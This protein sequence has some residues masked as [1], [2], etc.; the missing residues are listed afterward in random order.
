MARQTIHAKVYSRTFG[1]AGPGPITT[2]TK[3]LT[4]ERRDG[5]GEFRAEFPANDTRLDLITIKENYLEFE[6]GGKF[7]FFGLVEQMR[8]EMDD[9]GKQIVVISGRDQ[10]GALAEN[11]VGELSMA[12][13]YDAPAQILGASNVPNQNFNLSASGQPI[14][15]TAYT[16]LFAGESALSALWKV[17]SDLGEHFRTPKARLLEVVWMGVATPDA[18]VRLV[19]TG[20]PLLHENPDVAIIE[21]VERDQNGEQMANRIYPFGAGIGAARLTLEHATNAMPTGYTMN[22]S[23]NYIQN[24]AQQ[25][26]P[27]VRKAIQKTWNHI[28]VDVGQTYVIEV[29]ATATTGAT[30]IA[31]ESIAIP[32]AS[33]TLL[34]LNGGGTDFVELSANVSVG[35]NVLNVVATTFDVLDTDTLIYTN[36]EA[37]EAA[38]RQLAFAALTYLQRVS[39]PSRMVSYRLTVRGLPDA[40]T[41]GMKIPVLSQAPGFRI[42]DDLIILEIR[43]T[44]T[45]QGQT[46]AV[47]T[48]VPIDWFDL[49]EAGSIAATMEDFRVSQAQGQPVAYSSI[50]SAPTAYSAGSAIDINGSNVISVKR[51]SDGAITIG[52]TGGLEVN[53][54]NGIKID[55]NALTLDLATDPGLEYA[56]GKLQ[57]KLK[58]GMTAMVRDAGGIYIADAIAGNGLTIN[59][60]TKVMAVGAGDGIDVDA[61]SVAVDV[62]DIIDGSSAYGLT[63]SGNNIRIAL[64]TNSGL[65]FNAGLAMGTPSALSVG[66][67]SHV[68]SSTHAHAVTTSSDVGTSPVA[69]ILASNASGQLTLA[70][71]TLHGNLVFAGGDRSVTASNKLTLAPSGDLLLDPTGS[72]LIPT[73]QEVKTETFS[74]LVTG[75][76]G[77]RMW[78][79]G[80]NYRQM[81]IG[82]IKADEMFVRVFVADE[83]RIDR[84]EEYWSKSYGVVETDF[85]LPADEA[86]VDVWFE[87][88]PGL[89]AANLFSTSDW[90]LARTIDWDTSLTIQKIWFQVVSLLTA[91]SVDGYKQQWRIRRKSGGTTGQVVKAGNTLLDAG[92]VG[93]GWI[94]L[95]A[96]EQD[97]GPFIQIGEYTS[98]SSDVPQFTN[99]VRIGN[100][101]GTL[102]YAT[103]IWGQ[104]AG[105]D[106]GTTPSAGFSG[107]AVDATNGLR[108]FNTQIS[109]YD[110]GT[111]VVNFNKD[112]GLN[113]DMDVSEGATWGRYVRWHPDVDSMDTTNSV[114]IGAYKDSADNVLYLRN[115]G[116]NGTTPKFY[117]R[118][119]ET[120]GLTSSLF[121]ST[122]RVTLTANSGLG[123]IIDMIYGVTDNRGRI[124]VSASAS[125]TPASTL[126]VYEN[127][128]ATGTNAGATIEQDGTGDAVLQWLLT[129]GQ[130][131]AM[132]IDNSDGDKFKI[133]ANANVGTS[134]LVTIDPSSGY[135]TL[136]NNAR[137][138]ADA[139]QARD[140]SGLALYDDGGNL[141]V[142]VADGGNVG[143][144]ISAPLH[145]LHVA[146]DIAGTAAS[147]YP[148]VMLLNPTFT[149]N[150][151]NNGSSIEIKTRLDAALT[152]AFAQMHV[153]D[154]DV[155][156]T[157]SATYVIGLH[158]SEQTFGTNNTNLYI[159]S[160]AGFATAPS[161]DWALYSASTRTSYFGGRVGI[162]GAPE[163]DDQLTVKGI[164]ASRP[165]S[166]NADL[167]LLGSG[168]SGVSYA[169]FS[170]TSGNFGVY[171]GTS[172]ATRL[173]INSSG[174][175]GL[176]GETSPGAWIDLSA[177]VGGV[178]LVRPTNYG[179]NQYHLL[180]RTARGTKASPTQALNG[181][182]LMA[183]GGWGYTSSG[184]ASDASAD[185]TFRATESFTSSARGAKQNF[186]VTKN[187]TN[188]LSLA[189]ELGDDRQAFLPG[190]YA[191]TTGSGANVNVDASGWL[192]LSTSSERYKTDIRPMPSLSGLFD[193]LVPVLYKPA[194]G[195]GGGDRDYPGLIAER[196]VEA[197]GG[198]FVTFDDEGRPQAIMYDRLV[199][200]T[201]AEVQAL[202][203]RIA[204]LERKLA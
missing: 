171:D 148:R 11:T 134:T 73:A 63:E 24:D 117:A 46:P 137:F 131:W 28:G 173:L 10:L 142:A 8:T 183:L 169:V 55:T 106:L 133:A 21:R 121:M 138:V 175:M 59:A 187:G 185:I 95:S 201:I 170:D 107:Y 113:I 76:A 114:S 49:G 161:G 164:I 105:D 6:V 100:L 54:G 163:F 150:P 136:A 156:S 80:S 56:S 93:Q 13:A 69:A 135:I 196:V 23:E 47:V 60:T 112:D 116:L 166:G 172:F 78:D 12:F 203:G 102:D 140:S 204:E 90:L 195:V 144:K 71:L 22:T 147:G 75:I 94:H 15:A 180:G 3:L 153:N 109:L 36:P 191:H 126:H 42:D 162:G 96:L 168:G 186:Y 26:L 25:S 190:V 198:D 16:K 64:A 83:V 101:N 88:S 104:A 4:V 45:R 14:T 197:G 154:V 89:A 160:G 87:N 159:K 122:E 92:Q 66:S 37:Q 192:R 146:G 119:V 165:T 127:S 155:L 132:G 38:A 177:D 29:T 110:S 79:R 1:L 27:S 39:E 74:D 145:P 181:T 200:L 141:G 128:T 32:L 51:E 72:V 5:A 120:G 176:G 123:G 108:L 34:D 189:M 67:S 9:E 19:G 158:V 103:D 33:G 30:T 20:G 118:V 81:T 99:Y 85:T 77:M 199:V 174:R 31:V 188:I 157:G 41:V 53:V 149:S 84:G 143:V 58:S 184:W 152:S 50:V 68:T 179:A 97:G 48:V 70:Q 182:P 43:R 98:V 40:V 86:T 151:T 124:L 7:F 35:A 82:A 44:V 57:V 65:T 52:G 111:R 178:P 139:V 91:G 130:R 202:K 61:N 167:K 18:P 125:V 17:A 129:G 115:T 2:C 194:A 193:Q 62:T